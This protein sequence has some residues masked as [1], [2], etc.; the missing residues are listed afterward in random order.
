VLFELFTAN[1]NAYGR[2]VWLQ[3]HTNET[4]RPY[5]VI[6]G[7]DRSAW[8]SD[9]S[10]QFASACVCIQVNVYIMVASEIVIIRDT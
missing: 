5:L 6:G 7:Y 9:F 2:P 10:V 1:A 8:T 3:A 4:R